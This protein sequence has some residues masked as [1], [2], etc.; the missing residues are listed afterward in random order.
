MNLTH[1][2]P[3]KLLEKA[4]VT[5]VSLLLFSLLII[6][7]LEPSI[8]TTTLWPGWVPTECYPWQ[9]L[10]FLG[11]LIVFLGVLMYGVLH[12]WRWLFW[13]L[14]IAFAGSVIQIPVESLQ[15]LG[16]FPNPYPVWYSLFRGG[17]GC[18]EF[19]FA[20]W[21]LQTHRHQGTWGMGR[22]NERM[23]LLTRTRTGR[24]QS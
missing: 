23:S 15:L 22:K 10:L 6:F 14:L 21:M 11:A 20:F 8:Y 9:I 5:F 13:P 2:H 3:V 7:A 19:A 1:H 4:L 18:I 24:D 12:H 16:V 17:V